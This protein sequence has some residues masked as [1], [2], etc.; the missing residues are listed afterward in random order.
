VENI[1]LRGSI[2]KSI[3]FIV[4]FANRI[5]LVP[6]FLIY[7]GAEKYGVWITLFSIYNLLLAI[8]AG[9]CQYISNEF[10][11]CFHTEKE[12]AKS[13][14]G[15]GV[16][17]IYLS[18]LLQLILISAVL[19][20]GGMDLLFA[21]TAI[22]PTSIYKGIIALLIYRMCIGSL[23]GMILRIIYPT[24]RIDRAL[25][26]GTGEKIIEVGVL[27][28]GG[29]AQLEVHEV[30][31]L[32]AVTKGMYAIWMLILLR[33]WLPEFFPWWRRGTVRE[34]LR[35]YFL[36]MAL[37][38]NHFVE[39]VTTDGLNI[40]VS[41]I[42]G[43]LLVPVLTTTRTIAALATRITIIILTPLQPELTR[44]HVTNQLHKVIESIKANWFLTGIVLNAPFILLAYVIQPLYAIWTGGEIEF[45]ASL[46][47]ATVISVLL[48]NYGAGYIYYLRA[49]NHIRGLMTIT[50]IRSGLLLVSSILLV[51]EMGL[52]G[53]GVALLLTEL[54]TAIVLPE[55]IVSKVL[56]KHALSFGVRGK[57][58]AL[59]SVGVTAVFLA[60]DT[61]V[62]QSLFM[63][64]GAVLALAALTIAQW[65]NLDTAVR[66]RLISVVGIKR[67][68]RL[69]TRN[70]DR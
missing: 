25:H 64:I 69:M 5:L 44:Y 31:Y 38:V 32:F 12:K 26:I 7:W 63:G 13:L 40:L 60:L 27:A 46:Y 14:L 51:R 2:A 35:N 70:H 53:V 6:V 23:K 4:Y 48:L 22:E 9:H 54:V 17:I 52:V 37:T 8:D 20:L 21:E 16:R 43:P 67:L 45:D 59:G 36:S 41:G 61:Y 18:G 19:L 58:L 34:G 30:C 29:F 62:I 56:R 65:K 42:L 50:F 49:I 68:Q 11:K 47:I 1:L 39:K 57:M 66:T 3:Q 24:G 10:N 28:V 15:S 55:H 33:R